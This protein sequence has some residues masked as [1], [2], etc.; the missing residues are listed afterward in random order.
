MEAIWQRVAWTSFFLPGSFLAFSDI[1]ISTSFY[2]KVWWSNKISFCSKTGQSLNLNLTHTNLASKDPTRTLNKTLVGSRAEGGGWQGG[3]GKWC[4][5]FGLVCV[6]ACHFLLTKPS[7]CWS[8]SSG[9][10]NKWRQQTATPFVSA[11]TSMQQNISTW[12]PQVPIHVLNGF[13]CFLGPLIAIVYDI[14]DHLYTQ[15]SDP[16]SF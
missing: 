6:L 8:W 9:E 2:P 3:S 15:T 5:C 4:W 13:P 14:I 11:F 16:S 10:A 1:S 12:P 7:S